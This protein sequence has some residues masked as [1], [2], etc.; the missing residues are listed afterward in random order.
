MIARVWF[1]P[2]L[3]LCAEPV[4]ATDNYSYKADEYAIISDGRSPD[5]RWSVAAHGEG[6]AGYENFDLYL[7]REPAREK[8]TPLR[9]SDCLDTNPLSIFAVW[10][11]DSRHVALLN[12]SDRHVLDLR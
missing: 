2:L 12:R 4:V 7:I 1:A 8:P 9:T 3:L 5:G 6:E 10:A 11:P